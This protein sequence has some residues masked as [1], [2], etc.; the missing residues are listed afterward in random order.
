MLRASGADAGC[1]WRVGPS[2]ERRYPRW[3]TRR[4]SH[5]APAPQDVLRNPTCVNGNTHGRVRAIEKRRTHE[6]A[7]ALD[8]LRK[9][10]RLVF[11]GRTLELRQLRDDWIGQ[12]WPKIISLLNSA[13]SEQAIRH[14]R[15]RARPN[16]V[17]EERSRSS[18]RFDRIGP[19]DCI[20]QQGRRIVLWAEDVVAS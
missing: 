9:L 13:S 20:H 8:D 2:R 15:E 7:S 6:G 19:A 18:I 4:A 1:D 17:I 16:S 10:L 5:R 14:S 3:M 12:R 11:T